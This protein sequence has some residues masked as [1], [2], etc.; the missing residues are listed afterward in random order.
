MTLGAGLAVVL[1]V[2]LVWAI[3]A[4]TGSRSNKDTAAPAAVTVGSAGAAVKDY[5]EAL[6][7]G[8]AAAALAYGDTR[9]AQPNLLTDDILRQQLAQW[10]LTNI[11]ILSQEAAGAEAN[12]HVSADFGDQTSDATVLVRKNDSGQWKLPSAAIKIA[13]SD[14][15]MVPMGA[16]RTTTVFGQ[17]I[18]AA[19]TYVF[20]GYLQLGSTSSYLRADTSRPLLLDALNLVTNDGL[21]LAAAF[22]L[23]DDKVR[24]ALNDAIDAALA[25]CAHTTLL[26]PPGRC[27]KVADAAG[28]VEGTVARGEI[29]PSGVRVEKF[30]PVLMYATVRGPATMSASAREASGATRHEDL[31]FSLEG[32]LDLAADP[33]KIEDWV[34]PA[35]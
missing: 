23:N 4:V 10:P 3:A 12:V 2:G 8:D 27:P 32:E 5:L 19:G 28:L 29:D 11:T 13:G 14:S 34:V 35:A 9:P 15:P 21:N 1:V 25:M 26:D 31:R 20:P 16:A 7:R 24:P 30:N 18:P 6:A 33:P 22:A 17:P